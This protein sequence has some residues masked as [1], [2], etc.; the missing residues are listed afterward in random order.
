MRQAAAPFQTTASTSGSSSAAASHDGR[1]TLGASQTS[2][3]KP[4]LGQTRDDAIPTSA[5][6]SH[7]FAV[8]ESGC[9]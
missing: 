6:G 1:F 9:R 3:N 2:A 5:L 8:T 7:A 4:T